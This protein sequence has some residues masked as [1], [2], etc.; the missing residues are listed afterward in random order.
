MS[1]VVQDPQEFFKSCQKRLGRGGRLGV[2]ALLFDPN[3]E[4]RAHIGFN[5][6]DRFPMASVV[7]VP[8]GMLIASEIANG[9]LS[10]DE[11]ITIHS[12]AASPGLFA[13]PLDRF[14]FLPFAIVRTHTVEQLMAFIF[15]HSDNTATDAIL[16]RLG[17][18]SALT[19]FLR[20]LQIE[21]ISIKRTM[22][23]LLTY[24]Y[25][26]QPSDVSEE[27]H[28]RASQRIGRILANVRCIIPAFRCR[29]DREEDLIHSGEETCT[30]RA[31]A[32]LLK[33]L[34]M[35]PK[36]AL[37]YSHMQR[38]ATNKRRIAEGLKEQG[39]FV[40]S[41]GHKTG[42]L[43][44]IA[45]DVGIVQFKNGCSAVLAVMT[46]HSAVRMRVRDDE[47]ATVTRA[48]IGQWKTEQLFESS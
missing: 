36:Y 42:S 24:Y 4:R 31:M 2:S 23:E 14:Y 46:C 5:E 29:P 11:K 48:V 22:H 3:G 35:N 33:L 26:L 21:G 18:T 1:T 44:A 34:T 19:N 6:D 41:F 17:G 13:N 38:C 40:K 9:T 43:G 8:I 15:R 16:H 7:K 28:P 47:I 30:P 37:V 39:V 10:L 27:H 45:N 32:Q 20:D 12:R 25:A